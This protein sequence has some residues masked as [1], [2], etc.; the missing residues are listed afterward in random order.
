MVP[1]IIFF[2]L[3]AMLFI[4]AYLLYFKEAYWLISGINFSPR[5]TVRERYDLTGL[6]KHL[7]RMCALIGMVLLIS[8]V[9]AFLGQEILFAGTIFSIFIIIP[10][11]LFGTEKY[12]Y[13][14]R[15][16]QRIIN[17]AITALM[18][19]V[20]VF[21]IITTV[22]GS[23]PPVIQITDDSVEIQS[24][25]GTEIPLDSI[26]SVDLFDLAGCEIIKLN[27]FNLGDN[28]KGKFDVKGIG[29]VTLYQQGKPCSSVL[30]WTAD[31]K[32]LIDLGSE[33]ENNKLRSQIISAMERS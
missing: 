22:S 26:R 8:G 31:R 6:T 29:T 9:G 33:E 11:F 25:Y 10:V 24:M 21:V 5:E 16:T 1:G 13:V 27:G 32:Y 15:K 3:S 28:R 12:M 14:G 7:A 2:A 18:T 20:A 17:I 30:I 19:L 23:K 4:F